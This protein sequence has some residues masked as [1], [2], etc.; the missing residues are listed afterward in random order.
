MVGQRLWK[1]SSLCIPA[2][3]LLAA[4]VQGEDEDVAR[5]K[6]LVTRLGCME[7]HTALGKGAGI[8]AQVKAPE[9]ARTLGTMVEMENGEEVEVTWDYLITS[10]TKPD[11]QIVKGYP[12]GKM[13]KNFAYLPKKDVA[14]IV[15]YIESLTPSEAS[16]ANPFVKKSRDVA[17]GAKLIQWLGCM[18]CHAAQGKAP[19]WAETLGTTVEMESGEEFKVTRDYLVKSIMEPDA[20]VVKGYSAG[21]MP[22]WFAELPKKDL[23]AIVAYIESLTTSAATQTSDGRREAGEKFDDK[24]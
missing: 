18:E 11:A 12:A 8:F 17:R 9:W 6:K 4:A 24:H 3:L 10:I 2:F 16:E 13:P 20:H 23:A 7:C 1:F 22:T 5:G 14:A 19:A 21:E 15:T